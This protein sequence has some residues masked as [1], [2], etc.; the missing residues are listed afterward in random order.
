MSQQGS[1]SQNTT[2]PN[3]LHYFCPGT[4]V[5][6]LIVCSIVA[7]LGALVPSGQTRPIETR[8]LSAGEMTTVFGDVTSN[9]MCYNSYSCLCQRTGKY[10]DQNGNQ[11]DVC[12]YCDNSEN[13]GGT[14]TWAPCC[15]G[16]GLYC[17]Q[18][19]SQPCNNMFVYYYTG[20]ESNSDCCDQCTA[21][22]EATP[23]S[24]SCPA[25]KDYGTGSQQCES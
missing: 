2:A 10:T 8:L 25:R 15:S 14:Q 3:F 24:T 22:G 9:N 4:L 13:L 5:F 11:F 19:G 12:E 23:T 6:S 7:I 1:I 17:S 16:T 20:Y 21:S 18:N